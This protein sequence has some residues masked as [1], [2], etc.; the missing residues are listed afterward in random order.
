MLDK[1]TK[2]LH[3]NLLY[4]LIYQIFFYF[5]RL[6][7]EQV[8][9][10]CL[11]FIFAPKFVEPPLKLRDPV[12]KNIDCGIWTE[13]SIESFVQMRLTGNFP[14]NVVL[15]GVTGDQGLFCWLQEVR[16]NELIIPML[17]P[18]IHLAKQK[19]SLYLDFS[20]FQLQ[21]IVSILINRYSTRGSFCNKIIPY[22]FLIKFWTNWTYDIF[23]K[24][25]PR[26]FWFDEESN[27]IILVQ[28]ELPVL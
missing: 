1:K 6:W 25:S 5:I 3:K 24:W 13:S 14:Q 27:G 23:G 10:I 26:R 15:G 22:V 2:C 11:V 28:A 21:R 20:P 4:H 17:L 19:S 7:Q 9:I 8:Q 12:V 18:S 16:F